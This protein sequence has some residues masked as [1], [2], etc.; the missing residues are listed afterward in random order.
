MPT[1]PTAATT[2][3]ARAYSYLRFSTAEQASGGSLRR[4]TELAEDYAALHGM[5]LDRA[6]SLSDLGVSAFRGDNASH[7]N[8]KAFRTAIEQGVVAPGSFLLVESLDR[9]SRT[10]AR[11]AL[12]LIEEIVEAGV[13]VVTLSDGRQYTAESLDGMDIMW[14]LMVMFRAN[15]ESEMKSQRQKAVWLSKR[16]TLAT[17][18]FTRRTPA[19]IALDAERKRVLIAER[20]AVI[21]TM[22]GWALAGAGKHGI[23]QRLNQAGVKTFGRAPYWEPT[24]VSSILTTPALVGTFVPHMFIHQDGRRIRIALTPVPNYFPAVL[25]PE[26]FTALQATLLRARG[27]GGRTNQTLRNVLTRLARCPYCGGPMTRLNCSVRSRPR[28]ECR[29]AVTHAGCHRVPVI[30]ADIDHAL[31]QQADYLI[32]QVPSPDATVQHELHD[33]ETVIARLEHRLR[34]LL[35]SPKHPNAR[36]GDQRVARLQTSM[37][38]AR[39]LRDRLQDRAQRPEMRL[40]TLK[41]DELSAALHSAPVDIRRVNAALRAL[42]ASVVVDH[43]RGALVLQW[44]LGGETSLQYGLRAH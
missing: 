20:V 7:G 4:Q 38:E 10:T 3:K 30:V 24:Y 43:T 42:V 9:L 1:S 13:T 39:T 26:T 19:W 37:D 18:T 22:V 12:R 32:S 36:A 15:E 31:S 35:G 6:L 16:Q 17:R 28:L 41:T 11:K 44:K 25:D 14:A 23:A 33:A 5:E 34:T 40:N 2:P 27:T 29:K 8:L 21:Q